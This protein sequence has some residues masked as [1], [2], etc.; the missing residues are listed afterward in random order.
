MT[1]DREARDARSL[2]KA[3]NDARKPLSARRAVHAY[4]IVS[5]PRLRHSH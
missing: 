2:I 1:T 3:K 5:S 4:G